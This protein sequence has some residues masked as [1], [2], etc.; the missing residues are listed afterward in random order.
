MASLDLSFDYVAFDTT[1]KRVKGSIVAADEGVA[2]EQLKRQGL[3]PLQLRRALRGGKRRSRELSDR[4]ASQFLSDLAALLKAGADIRT[5]L[6]VIGAK[7]EGPAVSEVC[8]SLGADIGAGVALERAFS[9]SLGRKHAFVPALVAAGES[10]SDIAGGLERAAS[11]LT[12]QVKVRDQMVTALSYPA[13]VLATSIVALSAILL[14]VVPSLA[15]LMDQ[16]GVTPPLPMLVLIGIS[17]FIRS[18]SMLLVGAAAASVIA[19]LAM[20]RMGLVAAMADRFIVAGP[21]RRISGG[22]I[23]GGFAISL[24]DMLAAGASMA[25]ALRLATRSVS[26]LSARRAIERVAPDV[27]QGRRLSETLARVPGFPQGI[28]RLA[29]IGEASGSLGPMIAR[30]GQ[31]EEAAALRRIEALGRFIGPAVIVVLGGF[32][33]LIM[34]GLLTS[35]TH[36][37]DAALQ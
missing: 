33:G 23:Y 25:D 4:E 29:A 19:L 15:P 11:L 13:F 3:A 30:A 17:G 20:A 9:R 34:G 6:T 22:L 1:G 16:P 2:F 7:S 35:I 26:S 37:G 12:S 21:F 27:R 14:F 28:I 36:I 5:S 18:H 24:G 10:A 8:K 32:I 31:V